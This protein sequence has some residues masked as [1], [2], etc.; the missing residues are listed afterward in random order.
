MVFIVALP[1]LKYFIIIII[2][3]FLNC[4]NSVCLSGSVHG[5]SLSKMADCNSLDLKVVVPGRATFT[6]WVSSIV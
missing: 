6:T 3:F 5:A 2:I 4:K 1:P